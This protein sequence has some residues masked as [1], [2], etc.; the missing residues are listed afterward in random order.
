MKNWIYFL[1]LLLG[2][3]AEVTATSSLKYTHEFTRL[4]PTVGVLICYII[5]LFFLTLC[6]RVIPVGIAYA[7]WAGAG[8][9]LVA[10]LGYVLHQQKL[11]FFAVLGIILITTGVLIINLLSKSISH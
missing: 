5:S 10:I 6:L 7:I 2:I 8:I 4:W 1:Y 9:V 3:I 11:D